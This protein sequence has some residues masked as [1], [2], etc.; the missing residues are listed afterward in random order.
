MYVTDANAL[1]LHRLGD[2]WQIQGRCC[3]KTR[4]V[5]ETVRT[6]PA[7]FDSDSAKKSYNV[8]WIVGDS[9]GCIRALKVVIPMKRELLAANTCYTA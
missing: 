2:Q 5:K 7:N 1:H 3:R 9:D 6:Q 4:A 8:S